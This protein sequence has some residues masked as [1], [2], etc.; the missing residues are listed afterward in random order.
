[1]LKIPDKGGGGQ[2]IRADRDALRISRKLCHQDILW[3]SP[4]SP[5]K[6][7]CIPPLLLRLTHA[8][9]VM[10][11]LKFQLFQDVLVF[12]FDFRKKCCRCLQYQVC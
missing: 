12:S 1:M 3:S 10:K 2:Q 11:Y 7:L 8:S 6:T 9:F 4:A 5:C